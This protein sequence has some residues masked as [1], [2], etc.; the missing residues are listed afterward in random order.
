ML[1]LKGQH[2]GSLSYLQDILKREG[3]RLQLLSGPYAAF[4]HEDLL[5]ESAGAGGIGISA[6]EIDEFAPRACKHIIYN[7]YIYYIYDILYISTFRVI[8]Q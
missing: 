1:G 2:Q 7:I 3:F 4:L 8:Q 5:T 6:P